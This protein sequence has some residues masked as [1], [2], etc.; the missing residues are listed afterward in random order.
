M[1]FT[2]K[3][4]YLMDKG[5]YASTEYE[6]D[7]DLIDYMMKNKEILD[8]SRG[9]L[10]SHNTM[11]TGFSTTDMEELEDNSEFH[12][13]YLSM[14]VNN[15][16]EFNAKVAFRGKKEEKV[17]LFMSFRDVKGDRS[18]KK[19]ER[20]IKEDTL[21][22]ADCEVVVYYDVTEELMKRIEEVCKK[23]DDKKKT[24]WNQQCKIPYGN[25]YTGWY[26]HYDADRYKSI[27]SSPMIFTTNDVEGYL[28]KLLSLDVNTKMSVT[29]VLKKIDKN[30][31]YDNVNF[32]ESSWDIYLETLTANIEKVFKSV[33]RTTTHT[34]DDI[35]SLL[36]QCLKKLEAYSKEFS[37]SN[38]IYDTL[39]LQ[40]KKE[41]EIIGV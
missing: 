17:N 37:S 11:S 19:E 2:L 33:F 6:T 14:I 23:A 35:D 41:T 15:S 20:I 38:D 16:N 32:D 31:N 5:T 29:E 25:D 12:N 26:D 40:I 8:C 21:F 34:Q 7:A 27:A 18:T 28:S 39:F 13:C 36:I 30:Y 22:I 3:D 10:H 9:H 24:K 4:V 1:V